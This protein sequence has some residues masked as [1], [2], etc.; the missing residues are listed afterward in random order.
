MQIVSYHVAGLEPG[1]FTFWTPPDTA[2]PVLT[3]YPGG[4]GQCDQQLR[5]VGGA[6]ASD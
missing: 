1:G 3:I 6:E 2:P 4:V 5:K